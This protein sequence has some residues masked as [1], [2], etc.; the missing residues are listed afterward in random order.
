[1][2]RNFSLI[3]TFRMSSLTTQVHFVYTVYKFWVF[4][5]IFLDLLGLLV[6]YKQLQRSFRN[7]HKDVSKLR[8]EDKDVDD[9]ISY[10]LLFQKLPLI[11]NSNI[12]R[13][14]KEMSALENKITRVNDKVTAECQDD[15]NFSVYIF[16]V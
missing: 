5:N 13:I 11:L 9:L 1:M 16:F 15:E 10:A 12:S 6:Q 14:R 3:L 7:T 8:K 2:W 4:F